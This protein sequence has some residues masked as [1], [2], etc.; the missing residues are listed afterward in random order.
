MKFFQGLKNLFTNERFQIVYGIFL[1]ILMPLII[2]INTLY[3]IS[4][5]NRD[6]DVALQRSALLLGNAF[7][8]SSRDDLSDI[9][10]L[11]QN[12]ERLSK[13]S[14]DILDIQILFPKEDGFEIAAALHREDIGKKANYNY[15]H[16]A[17]Q[18][19]EYEALATDALP[20]SGIPEQDLKNIF[21]DVKRFWLVSMPLRD[22]ENKKVALFS[23]K[24]SSQIVDDLTDY[25]WKAS[26][27]SLTLTVLII[28]L[29]L[30][31]STRLW[32][33]VTLYQKMKD[34]DRM[35]DEFISIA[36]HELRT[37]ITAIRGYASMVLEG[38]FGAIPD[39][40]KDGLKRVMDS[41]NRLGMLI[42][43]I[44]NVSRIE[45]GRIQINFQPTDA[46]ACMVQTVEELSDIAKE[47][48]LQLIL[49][50][51]DETV[52][53]ISADPDKL[54][55]VFVNLIGNAIKYTKFGS[56]TVTV[57]LD[58]S[59][60][61]LL[62]KVKDT[63]IGISAKDQA[64]L[65]EK[66]FRVPTSETQKITGSGLG[67]WITKQLA[68]LMKGKI[69]IESMEGVGTHVILEFPIVKT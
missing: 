56:I 38:S 31:A 23:M 28:I 4:R 12:I 35:K 62:V 22:M 52:P 43:D 29:F 36:S 3:V 44:L 25:S 5:Y 7:Y 50:K 49:K 59:R 8:A 26:I 24:L 60:E 10:L 33:Y 41:A 69:A 63:G 42:E 40:L 68:E 57:Q 16:L 30:A 58:K 11:Q 20:I 19:K 48:K 15:Y 2:V 6:I 21:R 18:Q 13:A 53:K 67:L 39:K 37:P 65:F 9:G 54:K 55:Q 61:N 66:F 27:Y 45:Q 1:L 51:Q 47:K 14:A 46:V 64:R 17:W 32:G 34:V